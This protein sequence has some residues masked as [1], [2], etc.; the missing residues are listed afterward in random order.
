MVKLEIGVKRYIG[1]STD[2]KPFVGSYADGSL[3]GATLTTT[4]LAPGSTFF[5]SDTGK[6]WRWDGSRWTLPAVYDDSAAKL[7]AAVNGLRVEVTALRLGMIEAGNCR[8][9][10]QSDLQREMERV[11]A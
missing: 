1:L 3:T 11:E 10:S 9:L 6:I 8:E 5:E 7:L 2:T 4:D